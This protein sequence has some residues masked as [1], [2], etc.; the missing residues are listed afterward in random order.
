MKYK[1]KNAD[2]DSSGLLKLNSCQE[3]E[4]T[5]GWLVKTKMWRIHWPL[6]QI[7]RSREYFRL[8]SSL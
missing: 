1:G 6:R 7:T 2:V 8:P 4:S 5:S 3:L